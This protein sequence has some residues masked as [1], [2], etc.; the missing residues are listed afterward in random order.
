VRKNAGLPDT[1]PRPIKSPS[2]TPLFTKHAEEDIANQFV[3]AVEKFLNGGL[4]N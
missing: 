3:A 1:T 4:V 2:P